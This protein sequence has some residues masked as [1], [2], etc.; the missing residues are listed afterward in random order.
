MPHSPVFLQTSSTLSHTESIR[1]SVF[2]AER[3]RAVAEEA[4]RAKLYSIMACI[5]EIQK[6]NDSTGEQGVAFGHGGS[7]CLRHSNAVVW[8]G[9]NLPCP[10]SSFHCLS[11]EAMF[12]PLQDTV[13]LLD[14]FANPLEPE[15][16]QRLEDGPRQWRLL[17][18]KMFT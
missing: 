8:Q 3:A 18:R 9:P 13:A 10:A 17:S 5:R 4:R 1:A 14:R 12:K 7:V 6:R 2:D 15:L 16:L 11:A